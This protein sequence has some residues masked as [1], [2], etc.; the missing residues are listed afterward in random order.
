M[1]RTRKSGGPRPQVPAA[2]LLCTLVIRQN[3]GHLGPEPGVHGSHRAWQ[4][5]ARDSTGCLNLLVW[6]S[7]ANLE[8]RGARALA[9]LLPSCC[10]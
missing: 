6:S 10:F 2:P 8:H 3:P 4:M 9:T 7:H 5:L 1:K